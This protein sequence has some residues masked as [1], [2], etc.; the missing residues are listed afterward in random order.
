[1]VRK[2][3][4]LNKKW[5]KTGRPS[6]VIGV[7]LN[8]GEAVVGNMCAELRFDYTAIGDTVNLASRLEVMNKLY[9]TAIIV[10][11]NTHRLAKNKF[12]FRELD[13]VRVKGKEKPVAI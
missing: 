11:E 6:L 7:G 10:S 3:P 1:M 12:L 13:M 5:S 4:E 8:T 9:G 2:V